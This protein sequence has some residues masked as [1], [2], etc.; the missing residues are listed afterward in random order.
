RA[1]LRRVL[2]LPVP[3]NVRTT[4]GAHVR[5]VSL[6]VGVRL[7]GAVGGEVL[8]PTIR[9]T[10]LLTGE[11]GQVRVVL[12]PGAHTVIQGFGRFD[13]ALVVPLDLPLRP[14]VTTAR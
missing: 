2:Q 3:A 10:P 7:A 5:P 9:A 12:D 11:H 1:G 4:T 6:D 8:L 14:L 13:V